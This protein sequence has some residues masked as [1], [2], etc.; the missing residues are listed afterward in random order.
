MLGVIEA[1]PGIQFFFA[2]R[3]SHRLGNVLVESVHVLEQPGREILSAAQLRSFVLDAAF[4]LPHAF[5]ILVELLLI[6]LAEFALQALGILVDEIEDR[7]VILG[8]PG[9]LLRAAPEEAVEGDAGVDLA[10]Q[11]DGG[12]FPGDV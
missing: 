1:G 9:P 11:G 12:L 7:L 3:L 8:E 4:H 5:E 10:G 2:V 6:D